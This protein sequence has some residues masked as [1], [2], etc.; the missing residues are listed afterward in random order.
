MNGRVYDPTIGRFMS[1]DFVNQDPMDLQA[2]N[3]Y[4]YVRNNPLMYTDPSGQ[5]WGWVVAA[6]AE[7]F[8]QVGIIDKQTARSIQAVAIAFELGP[9]SGGSFGSAGVAGS[10]GAST[11]VAGA[12]AG[13]VGSD[14]TAEGAI[15]GG[16]SAALF[17]QVGSWTDGHGAN[18]DY[19][20]TAKH[21]ANIAGH[22]AVGCAMAAAQGGKCSE[23]A[24][25]AG[26][27]AAFTPLVPSGVPGLMITS[28][29]GG[30]ASVLGGGKFA[31]GA[32]T[33][34]FG[35]LFNAMS[36]VEQS[37]KQANALCANGMAS[38][39]CSQAIS[40]VDG[41]IQKTAKEQALE[42]V[43]PELILAGGSAISQ[44]AGPLKQW[45]RIG[46]S[47]SKVGQF[48]VDMSIRWGASPAGG[49]KYIQQIPSTTFQNVN[50]WLRSQQVPV[51][52]WR[53]ADPGHFHLWR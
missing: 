6:V 20:G 26:F 12:A 16:I 41:A 9:N 8:K 47:Y 28:A 42:T 53:A 3:R 18:S 5:F 48:Q 13:F 14:F 7:V 31:N 45:V 10:A 11:V 36:E 50:Q 49:G 37:Q 51:G 1:A 46:P 40:G 27:G 38:N 35:Y 44:A 22:A 19:F 32:V 23:G 34:A 2:Y 25:S 39:A 21:L 4:A 52:G 33:G 43:S 15:R 29:V 24:A 30:T 17:Y